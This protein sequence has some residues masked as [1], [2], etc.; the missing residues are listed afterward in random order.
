MGESKSEKFPAT[1]SAIGTE[2]IQVRKLSDNTKLRIYL[3]WLQKGKYLLKRRAAWAK[4]NSLTVPATN[5]HTHKNNPQPL[6]Q[7]KLE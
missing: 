6:F 1:I 5:H 7:A 2:D 4:K 3:T